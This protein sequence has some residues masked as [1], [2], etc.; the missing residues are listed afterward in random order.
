L[1]T[2]LPPI[3]TTQTLRPLTS[4]ELDDPGAARWFVIQLCASE[5]PFD[6]DSLPHLDIFSEYRLYAITLLDQGRRVQALRLG[7]FGEEVAARCVA[8]YLAAYYGQ[9]TVRRVSNAERERFADQR[10]EARKDIG[11]TGRHATI[12]ITGER[13]VRKAAPAGPAAGS[14]SNAGVTRAPAAGTSAPGS[15]RR[16][17]AP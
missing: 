9:P 17:A 2:P 16:P 15:T 7:F 5:Q 3:E 14:G 1:Q 8:S 13:T 11:A 10:V 4:L 6:P 12:E